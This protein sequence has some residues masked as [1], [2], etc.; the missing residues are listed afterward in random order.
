MEVIV[1]GLEKVVAGLERS[2]NSL[3]KATAALLVATAALQDATAALQ[4]A[5]AQLTDQI[6]CIKQIASNIKQGELCQA[7]VSEAKEKVL[8]KSPA[9]LHIDA[10]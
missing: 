4:D 2:N 8:P 5:K 10:P 6:E 3:Q 7:P 9:Q 1:K